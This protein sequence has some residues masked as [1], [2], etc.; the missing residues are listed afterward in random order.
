VK[1]S[2]FKKVAK[3]KVGDTKI[4]TKYTKKSKDQQVKMAKEIK[5]FKGTKDS[6]AYFQWTG[7]TNPKTGKSYK[8]KKSKATLAVNKLMKRKK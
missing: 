6:S 5:K 2:K 7:D 4:P 3:T 1:K 8:T